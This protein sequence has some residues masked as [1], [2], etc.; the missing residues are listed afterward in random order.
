MLTLFTTCKLFE[1][2]ASTIQANALRSWTLLR[3]RPEIIIYGG[4]GKEVAETLGLACRTRIQRESGYPLISALFEAAQASARHDVLA[5]VNADI[6]LTN[7]FVEAARIVAEQLPMFLMVGRRWDINVDYLLDFSQGWEDS[8]RRYAWRFGRLHDATGKDYFIFRRG[9]Y[10]NLPSFMVGQPAWDN[11]LLDHTLRRNIPV[12]DA[13]GTIFAAHQNHARAWTKEGTR[14]NRALHGRKGVG[15]IT[16]ATW[17]LDG[18]ELR[19]K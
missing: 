12:V 5:Y 1:G 15:H 18:K 17:T 16:H 2:L 10:Q 6:I 11:W 7:D 14:H 8:T 4:E 13:T 9:T 3:P 19:K